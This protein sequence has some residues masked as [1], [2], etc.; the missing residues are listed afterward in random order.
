MFSR[1]VGLM[2]ALALAACALPG[3]SVVAAGGAAGGQK[4]VLAQEARRFEW[5][6]QNLWGGGTGWETGRRFR[7]GWTN[8]H[9]QRIAKKARNQA[10]HRRACR[11]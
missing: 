9:Q 8:R 1:R 5:R 7:R 2:A 3:S 6:R 11:G 4:A 10:R